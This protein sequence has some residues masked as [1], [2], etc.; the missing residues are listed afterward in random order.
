MEAVLLSAR[1]L[2]LRLR[3]STK[4]CWRGVRRTSIFPTLTSIPAPRPSIRPARPAIR[5]AFILVTGNWCCTPWPLP[6]GCLVG[7]DPAGK[8]DLLPL[9]ANHFAHDAVRSGGW[10]G[11]F[12]WVEGDYRRFSPAKGSGE[13]GHGQG[14]RCFHRLRYVGDLPDHVACTT[15][16]F[17]DST[18]CRPA[19]RLP[20]QGRPANPAR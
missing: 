13:A 8:S 10:R 4:N 17:H 9:C 18:R 2:P 14:H 15:E 20:H 7:L 19:N 1:R 3:R 6:A 16:T 5:K 11:G 12:V